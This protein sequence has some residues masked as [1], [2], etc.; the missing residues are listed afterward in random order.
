MIV[1]LEIF[2]IIVNFILT[3][4][5]NQVQYLFV[6]VSSYDSNG[7]TKGVVRFNLPDPIKLKW[8]ILPEVSVLY[9]STHK[10]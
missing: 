1:E 10:R 8:D 2:W 9:S 6:F 7:H 5:P 4:H 3:L